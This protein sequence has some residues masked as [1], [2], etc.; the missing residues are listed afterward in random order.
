MN[1]KLPERASA[2]QLRI[3]AKELLATLPAGSKL[4]DAQFELAKSYGFASWPKLIEH[5]E[6]PG[7]TAEF[8]RLA[9]SGD[10]EALD[11]LLVENATLRDRINDPLFSFDSP[12][13]VW[14]SQQR[15]AAT[16]LPV[17]LRHGADPNA[18]SSW[19][20]GGFSALDLAGSAAVEIL[21]GAGAK[22]DTWSAAKHSRL[23]LLERFLADDPAS[24]NRPGGDGQTPLHVAGSAAVAR[25]LIAA[26]ADLEAR[27]VDHESTPIQYQINQPEIVRVLL[28]AG[29]KPDI[30]TAVA[31]DDPDLANL[32]LADDPHALE[33]KV[34]TPPFSTTQSDGGHIYLFHLG[35]QMTPMTLA[36]S[37]GKP[38]ILKALWEKLSP[39]EQLIAAMF[40]RDFKLVEDLLR[41]APS[42]QSFLPAAVGIVAH[43]AQQGHIELVKR[44]MEAGFDP[45]D[46]GLDGGSALHLAAWY[47][48]AEL[49][50]ILS[51]SVP[52]ELRDPTHGSTPLGWAVHG[53]N[54]CRNARGNYPATVEALIAAGAD[55]HVPANSGGTT[56]LD[57]AGDRKDIRDLLKRHMAAARG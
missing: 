52:I 7:L 25:M 43:A 40:S 49:I 1:K 41:Q 32:I 4:A 44:L 14:A 22:F 57:Q 29:A 55:P 54:W 11:R 13:I 35:N 36:A 3:Q 16:I 12:A 8:R 39:G 19:W 38:R 45:G 15:T 6:L 42:P 51:P 23:E 2:R 33:A 37:R 18:R 21:T 9:E 10:A 53:S 30:F 34:G 17:L 56:M 26:G 20:A 47:G 50:P 28:E 5:V 31:L 46:G 48:Y 24:V 27:D